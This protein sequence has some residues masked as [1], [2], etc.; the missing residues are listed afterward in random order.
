MWLGLR[1]DVDTYRG[2]RVGIP[3][4]CRL[5]ADRG[6]TA[7]FY[8][9]VGP[10]NMGRHFWRLFRPVFLWK[11]IRSHAPGLY[12]WDILLRGAFWPG[13]VIG[14]RLAGV[15]RAVAE[16]GH[17]IGF[18]AWDHHAWQARSEAMSPDEIHREIDRGVAM[19]ARITGRAPVTSAVPGWKCN[20]RV[21]L[22]KE[23]H[24]FR[25]NSD[26][27]GSEVFLPVVDGKALSQPQVPVTLPTYD[28]VAGI[29]SVADA[30]Y[31]GY[32]LS[33]L[34]PDRLNVLTIHAEVEGV[35]K[36]SLF[37]DFI[38]G[39]SRRGGELVPLGHL[40]PTGRIP[41]RARVGRGRLAGREG[42]VAIEERNGERIE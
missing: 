42:W 20:D 14:E 33:Q 34:S 41:T 39:L 30:D 3:N 10:D 31:N 32:M 11:M 24:P 16:S 2:T 8:F 9:S 7:T 15:I 38:D 4:L 21:L 22:E 25:Y 26:C 23:Q 37:A 28:E 17:E 13:P 18:H 27:R 19:L 5:F 36:L 40:L 35:S 6:I 29:G 12:G 1:V